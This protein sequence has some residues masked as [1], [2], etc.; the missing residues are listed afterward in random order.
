MVASQLV[1]NVCSAF[2][3]FQNTRFQT[4]TRWQKG[5]HSILLAHDPTR[6]ETIPLVRTVL[7]YTKKKLDAVLKRYRK[8]HAPDM[9]RVRLI[10]CDF[11]VRFRGFPV[12]SST[13]LSGYRKAFVLVGAR[14]IRA[15]N[16]C[17]SGVSPCCRCTCHNRVLEYPRTFLNAANPPPRG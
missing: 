5:S 8:T 12:R 9:Q 4:T 7:L 14:T 3:S 1:R 17:V 11:F 10:G 13:A 15:D 16:L 2:V 6:G